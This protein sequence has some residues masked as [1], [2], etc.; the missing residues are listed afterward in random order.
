[1]WFEMRYYSTYFF[2]NA[3]NNIVHGSINYQEKLEPFLD[4]ELFCYKYSKNSA[5]HR[6]IEYC[7]DIILHET[8]HQEL[9]DI[10]T[11]HSYILWIDNA[12]LYH[13]IENSGIDQWLVDKGKA[14]VTLNEDDIV[15]YYEYLESIGVMSKLKEIIVEEV[16]YILFLNREFLM[17]FNQLISDYQKMKEWDDIE[18]NNRD[19]YIRPGYL[20]RVTP[21]GWV[22]KAVFFRD[23]GV[24]VVCGTDLSNISRILEDR[25]IHYDH[26]VPLE[27]GGINDISNMQLTCQPHNHE[28]GT[29]AYTSNRYQ[30]WF[31][32]GKE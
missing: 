22:K 6:F 24:C 21:P 28:K 11:R 5:L 8:I 26:I 16:F 31:E 17:K 29:G 10:I 32:R 23:R 4:G 19:L 3:L 27:D 9:E 15:E 1:M 13:N 20:Q 14:K 7:F 2:A 25:E 18:I 12:L 30:K